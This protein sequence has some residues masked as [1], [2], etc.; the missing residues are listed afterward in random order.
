LSAS[1]EFKRPRRETGRGF[2][3]VGFPESDGGRTSWRHILPC[4]AARNV[5]SGPPSEL[6][7]ARFIHSGAR[8][9]MTA[10]LIALALA[11]LVIIVVWEELL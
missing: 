4:T 3:H 5:A 6:L 8:R 9:Q 7:D 1:Q 2:F 11:G 10:Y